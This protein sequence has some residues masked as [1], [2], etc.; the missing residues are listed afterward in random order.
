MLLKGM[1]WNHPRGYD[2]LVACTAVWRDRSCIDIAWE[3]R[4]LQDFESHPVED[5]ALRYDL[6]VIDH[7][8]V[9]QITAAGCLQPLDDPSRA[10]D[11]AALAGSSVGPSFDSYRWEGRLWALPIDAAAQV[12]AW[13]PDRIGAP[14]ESWTDIVD[15]AREGRVLWPMRPPHSLLSFLSLAANNGTPASCNPALPFVDPNAGEHVYRLM[16]AITEKLDQACF[17]MDPIAALDAMATPGAKAACV[18]LAYGYANYACSDF[19]SVRLAFAD[20]PVLGTRGPIGSVLG[21]TGIAVSARSKNISGATDFA[22]WVASEEVQRTIYA[23]AGGQPG[24]ASAWAD[25]RVNAPVRD[26]Y[27]ATRRTLEHAWV[28][29]RHDGYMPFQHA[30]SE[31]LNAGLQAGES[32][33]TVVADLNRTFRESLSA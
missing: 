5:L 12:Q 4:S 26:F 25:P 17:V 28:R 33:R 21:G 2:S 13:C 27:R 18:P 20:I 3:Q 7:P 22:Y 11:R 23:A 30:A 31:R 29:P 24:H 10:A 8:H 6:I 16:A 15:L 32:A 14:L 9:G 1:T 19:R